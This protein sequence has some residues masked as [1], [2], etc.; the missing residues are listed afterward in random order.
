M[1]TIT[2]GPS[3]LVSRTT[4]GLLAVVFSV[5][6]SLLSFGQSVEPAAAAENATDAPVSLDPFTVRADSGSRY[7]ASEVAT[8]SRYAVPIKD[9][10]F[11]VTLLDRAMMDDFVAFDFNDLASF[12]SSFSPSEGTGRFFMRGIASR[13]TYLNGVRDTGLFGT[14]FVE[15]VELIRGA[16]AAIY[17]QTEP[18]GLR[19]VVLL[20]PRS[21][22]EVQARVTIGSDDY[23]RYYFGANDVFA[24]GKLALRVDAYRED[25]KQRSINYWNSRQKGVYSAGRWQ[26]TSRTTVEYSVENIESQSPSTV[27]Q[28]LAVD[29][30]TRANL[31]VIGVQDIPAFPRDQ[32][33]GQTYVGSPS[34]NRLEVTAGDLSISHSFNAHLS[35]RL[36]VNHGRRKQNV[37][38]VNGT[39][40]VDNST[41]T[42]ALVANRT[43]W[44]QF[45][46]DLDERQTVAQLDLLAQFE[47]GATK[48]KLLATYDYLTVENEDM[49]LASL[50]GAERVDAPDYTRIGP[51]L[52]IPPYLTDSFRN[53]IDDRTIRGFLISERAILFGDKLHL[54]LG[55]RR[56]EVEITLTPRQFVGGSQNLLTPQV[57]PKVTA[58]TLQS[59]V[60]F[61]PMPD[62]SLYANYSESFNPGSPTDLDFNGSPIG[63]QE[64]EGMEAGIKASLFDERLN[65]TAGVYRIEKSN[66]PFTATNAAGSP[67]PPASGVGSYRVTGSQRSEG[68]ELDVTYAP[69]RAWVFS[70]SYGKNNVHWNEISPLAPR[71]QSLVGRAPEGVPLENFA[72]TGRYDFHDGVLKGLNVRTAMR[73]QGAASISPSITDAAGNLFYIPSYAL[74]DLGIG[75]AWKGFGAKHRVDFNLRNAFDKRYYRGGPFAG[76]PREVYLSY[77]L[78]F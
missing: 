71:N 78:R 40:I 4:S 36:V 54:L 47:I 41:R 11:P 74:W 43:S 75:Y 53:R 76:I 29:A 34:F 20:K 33:Y 46:E 37:L 16:N 73:Y 15:R 13:S 45:Y 3:S 56:D 57:Q 38:G 28:P 39:P 26:V 12:A 2:P 32:F 67:L 58:T 17:G 48:H 25:S 52:A 35:T 66:L 9:I 10:P 18:S 19:N 55:A 63:N 30:V 31:G 72:G 27:T 65:F 6:C 69:S 24:G 23:S 14:A 7:L 61:K 70:A 42:T 5:C 51:I 59:G 49:A 68:V 8:G 22:R 50:I 44:L 77:E 21:R 64:G 60:L 62:I 1:K